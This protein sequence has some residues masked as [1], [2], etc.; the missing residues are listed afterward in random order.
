MPRCTKKQA[1]PYSPQTMLVENGY[2]MSDKMEQ[3]GAREHTEYCPLWSSSLTC[4]GDVCKLKKTG[5][6]QNCGEFTESG[7]IF[8]TF[9]THAPR[10]PEIG[11]TGRHRRFPEQRGVLRSQVSYMMTVSVRWRRA[12]NHF[13]CVRVPSFPHVGKFTF[14]TRGLLSTRK[15]LIQKITPREKPTVKPTIVGEVTGTRSCQ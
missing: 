5:L 14:T 12:S 15:S 10:N 6:N 9:I 4:Y 7:H 8:I 1:Y 11:K 13:A 3:N 2:R